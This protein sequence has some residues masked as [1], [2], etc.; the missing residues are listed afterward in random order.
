MWPMVADPDLGAQQLYVALEMQSSN[1]E[2]AMHMKY[3]G[4]NL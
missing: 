3:C 1:A 2:S 4:I